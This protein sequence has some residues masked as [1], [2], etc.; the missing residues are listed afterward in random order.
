MKVAIYPGT[1]DPITNGHLDILHRAAAIFDQV[2]IAVAH[3]VQKSPLFSTEERI[4]LI[5]EC[6]KE[7]LNVKIKM[8]DGL[9]VEFAEKIGASVIIRGLRAVTDFDYEFQMALMNRHI[10]DN[11]DTMFLMPHED[12]TY[13]SSSTV[14]EIARFHGDISAFVPLNVRNEILK[15]LG[16]SQ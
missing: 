12:Y 1:F 10:N 13:L 4:K 14:K 3:N 9:V 11:I 8:L 2:Y 6:T 16:S 5:R 15:K 7:Y